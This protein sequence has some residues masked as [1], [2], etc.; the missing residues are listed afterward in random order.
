VHGSPNGFSLHINYTVSS[1]N[2][3]DVPVTFNLA[4]CQPTS[5]RLS[6]F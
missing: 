3:S 5:E 4:A 2:N 1:D 6:H